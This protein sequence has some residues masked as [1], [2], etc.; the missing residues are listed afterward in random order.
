M[1]PGQGMTGLVTDEAEAEDV[2]SLTTVRRMAAMLDQDG[3]QWRPGAPLP[4]G[5][6]VALFAPSP[7]QAMLRTDGYAG[8]GI[9][10]PDAGL[11]RLLFGGRRL[12]F[13]GDITI[14]TALRR[15]TRLL[16][17][18]PKQGRSGRMMVAT[19]GHTVLLGSTPVLTEEQDFLLLEAAPSPADAASADPLPA[20]LRSEEEVP[21]EEQVFVADKRMLLRFCALTFNT[22]RIHYDHPYATGVEGYPALVVNGSLTGL[23]LTELFRARARREPEALTSRN[24]RPLFCGRQNRLHAQPGA[25]G[26][27]GSW[28]LWAEDDAGRLA[29][30]MEAR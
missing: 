18:V 9:A 29:V 28:R 20:D 24:L 12:R 22:H 14:G 10:L 26:A 3:A 4:R 7:A 2:C 30:E 5:W 23:M 25:G 13:T 19:V 16:S 15:R 17:A 6:H 11:P 21:S 27:S 8:P 1:L